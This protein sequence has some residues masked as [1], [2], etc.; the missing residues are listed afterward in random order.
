MKE[1][2]SSLFKTLWILER[3]SSFHF[4]T[5]SID[6]SGQMKNQY[7]Y[8]STRIYKQIENI[9]FPLIFYFSL[10]NI[11]SKNEIEVNIN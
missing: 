5:K 4:C 8:T 9:F 2:R 10:I 1:T 7:I 11:N 3:N 6:S